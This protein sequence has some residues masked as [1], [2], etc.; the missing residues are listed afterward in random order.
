MQTARPPLCLVR[1]E[2]G[3]L[4]QPSGSSL[5]STG[6]PMP[7][8][9]AGVG[10]RTV[11]GNNGPTS[12]ALWTLQGPEEGQGGPGQP[13]GKLRLLIRPPDHSILSSPLVEKYNRLKVK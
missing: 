10:G 7:P 8:S 12:Q 3:H 4:L 9:A 11:G 6:C 2:V 5:S 1:P 13:L